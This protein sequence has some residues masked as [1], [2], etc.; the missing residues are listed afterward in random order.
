MVKTVKIFRLILQTFVTDL[1]LFV[2]D[3]LN[4]SCTL[5]DVE[6]ALCGFVRAL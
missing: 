1:K 2:M 3:G 6:T 4:G 5:L